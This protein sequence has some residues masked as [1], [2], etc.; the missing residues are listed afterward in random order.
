MKKIIFGTML[1]LLPPFSFAEESLDTIITREAARS[2]V[3]ESMI[4][5][6]INVESRGKPRAISNKGASGL[7]QLMPATAKRFGVTN[8]FNQ[9]Q[10]V[11]GGS[12][13]LA[14]LHKRFHGDWSLALAGY[15]AGEGAVDKYDGIP[16]YNETQHYVRLVLDRYEKLTNIKVKINTASN[17]GY[18]YKPK[19]KSTKVVR[20]KMKF[21]KS[22][23]T[24]LVFYSQY[25]EKALKAPTAVSWTPPE[26]YYD[27]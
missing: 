4:R 13:Y 22:E 20:S 21:R 1:F 5:A 6:V 18:V 27:N 16:P 10:N 17:H 26:G 8:I 15:N 19:K 24:K 14:W 23:T 12:T 2:G 7:M 3:S 11:K 25:N 9:A